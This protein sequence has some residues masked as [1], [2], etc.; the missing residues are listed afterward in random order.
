[1]M[2]YTGFTMSDLMHHLPA[3]D[4]EAAP[5]FESGKFETATFALG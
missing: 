2:A 1:M 4:R 5:I 3:V